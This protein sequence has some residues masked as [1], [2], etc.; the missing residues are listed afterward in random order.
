MSRLGLSGT[1]ACFANL[2]DRWDM[3]NSLTTSRHYAC[4]MTIAKRYVTVQV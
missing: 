2:A 4:V 1:T 3:C